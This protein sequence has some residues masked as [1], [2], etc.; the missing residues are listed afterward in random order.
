MHGPHLPGFAHFENRAGEGGRHSIWRV[1]CF[2][3]CRGKSDFEF[4]LENFGICKFQ[5]STMATTTAPRP[6]TGSPGSHI[7]V[8]F[9]EDGN[10]W[11]LLLNHNDSN[12]KWQSH[13]WT[14]IPNKV[15]KQF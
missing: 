6:M 2:I 8:V 10:E 7:C 13:S 3:R 9:G 4:S 1:F 14:G 15:A 5:S 11:L 12:R